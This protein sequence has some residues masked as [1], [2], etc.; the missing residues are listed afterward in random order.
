MNFKASVPIAFS[1][2]MNKY[3][4]FIFRIFVGCVFIYASIH[5]ILNPDAFADS[6]RNYLLVPPALTNLMAVSLPWV[7]IVCGIFLVAGLFP[8]SS[9]AVVSAMLAVFSSA[10]IISLARGLDIDCGCFDSGRGGEVINSLYVL[11]DLGLLF[12]SASV[13]LYDEGFCGLMRE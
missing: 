13:M 9:A 2:V 7:E 5:K 1:F 8:R 6:I 3:I 10:L 4:L 11:R 12:M